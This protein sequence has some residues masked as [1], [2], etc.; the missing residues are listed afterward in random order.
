[1]R[2]VLARKPFEVLCCLVERTGELVTKDELLAAVWSDLHVSESSLTVAVN[3]LR[4][5]LG[6]DRQAPHYIETV[7]RRGYRFIASVGSVQSSNCEQSLKE[8]I[9]VTDLTDQRRRWRVGRPGPLEV[10]EG[11]LHAGLARA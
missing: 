1:V 8:G 6:D 5:A 4:S 10:L 9:D 3:A 7:T 11:V 2:F